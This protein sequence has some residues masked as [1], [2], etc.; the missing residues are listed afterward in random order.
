M[1]SDRRSLPGA[2]PRPAI[3]TCAA[4]AGYTEDVVIRR[5]TGQSRKRHDMRLRTA[6]FLSLLLGGGACWGQGN[7][8]ASSADRS[9]AY[10]HY[11]LGHMYAE[12]AGNTTNRTEY[13]NLAI[14]NY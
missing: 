8:A 7:A 5:G 4:R 6:V 11:A 10:Y 13:V 14:E 12:L 2:D 3:V 1:R 9:T